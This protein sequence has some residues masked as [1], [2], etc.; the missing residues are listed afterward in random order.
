MHETRI[1]VLAAN[2]LNVVP[3]AISAASAG[4]LLKATDFPLMAASPVKAVAATEPVSQKIYAFLFIT[5]E[6]KEVIQYFHDA[7]KTLAKV[8]GDNCIIFTFER[9][10]SKIT[11]SV[12]RSQCY[13]IKE[14]FFSET[15]N[16][17]FPGIAFFSTISN[18]KY[19]FHIGTD[20]KFMRELLP[21]IF[22]FINR[23]LKNNTSI[24]PVEFFK[25][26]KKEKFKRTA[27]IK[28]TKMIS[29]MTISD[30]YEIITSP[31]KI[32]WGKG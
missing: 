13:D 5:D 27:K 19:Y 22:E 10:D 17:K 25:L 1:S 21:D 29:E 2:G 12:D 14:K 6:Y 26:L 18:E 4:T 15:P 31:F 11:K 8:S 7:H 24:E 23:T 32:I 16:I 9:M 20:E 28:L 3:S 30:F